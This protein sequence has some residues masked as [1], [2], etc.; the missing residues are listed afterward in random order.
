MVRLILLVL[1]LSVGVALAA[2]HR[3]IT[4]RD[5]MAVMKNK[6]NVV[7]V[8]VRTPG[9]YRQARIQGALLIPVDQFERRAGE[10]PKKGPV[11]IYCAVG[12]RSRMAAQ[13][14]ARLG[15]PEVYNMYDGLV[16]WYR[17]KLPL[18]Y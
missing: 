17:N 5:A 7:F 1:A 2:S 6:K 15:Y 4:S 11:V 16:G 14:L 8:D 10:V 18:Q 12:S 9:E 3:D 13:H